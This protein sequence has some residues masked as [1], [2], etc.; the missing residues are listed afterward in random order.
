MGGA[1]TG[2]ADD[3]LGIHRER[4][5]AAARTGFL[6]YPQRALRTKDFL[7]IRN[8]R[9]DR[10]PAGTPDH[11]HAFKE[12]A[13]LADCDNGPT[14]EYLWA[15]RDN[16]ALKRFSD[17]AFAKRPAEE[18]YDLSKDPGQINNVAE[19]ADYAVT[20]KKL[21]AALMA[22][23]KATKDPRALGKGKIFD[24]YPYYGGARPTKPK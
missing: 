6:P 5:V 4:H 7:Y 24:T 19:E 11:Q 16:P 14:K 8:F 15:N 10:W 3:G 23:L 17:L 20:K 18:L 1:S 13:W 21:A 2:A 22:Q 9:P 12:N